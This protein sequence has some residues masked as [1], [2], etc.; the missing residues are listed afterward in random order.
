MFCAGHLRAVKTLN[1]FA[2]L[3]KLLDHS[4]E[5][6]TEVADLVVALGEVHGDVHVTVGNAGDLVL[7]LDHGATNDDGQH[8]DHHCADGDGA[9]G[10]D[11]EY[12]VTFRIPEREGDE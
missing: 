12:S 2:T 8:H 4:V 10:S 1:L 5:V 9:G 11:D 6:A 7:K 3:A